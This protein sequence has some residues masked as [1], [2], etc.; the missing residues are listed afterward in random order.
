[1]VAALVAFATVAAAQTNTG[2]VAGVV[3]DASGGVLPGATVTATHPASGAVVSRVTDGEG[4]FFL[5]ALRAGAWDVTVALA[6]FS[7]Q[8]RTGTPSAEACSNST[9]TMRRASGLLA[10]VSHVRSVRLQADR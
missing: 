9:A 5:P 6:G 10:R 3:M 8:T 4:R 2:E 7:P 1:V